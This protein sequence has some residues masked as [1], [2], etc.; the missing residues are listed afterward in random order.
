MDDNNEVVDVPQE[1]S[2]ITLEVQREI[3]SNFRTFFNAEGLPHFDI[4][5]RNMEIM[6]L[7]SEIEARDK[8]IEFLTKGSKSPEE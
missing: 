4:A 5:A 3:I 2:P 1:N 6:R 8:L 7:A